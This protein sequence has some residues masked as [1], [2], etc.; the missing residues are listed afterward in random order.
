[1]TSVATFIATPSQAGLAISAAR[2]GDCYNSRSF[3]K[4]LL[5]NGLAQ[6]G[7]ANKIFGIQS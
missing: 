1:M 2:L 4:E 3:P 6:A 7:L 5:A